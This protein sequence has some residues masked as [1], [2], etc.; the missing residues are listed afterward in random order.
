MFSFRG[1]R[2]AAA[3]PCFNSVKSRSGM[4][5]ANVGKISAVVDPAPR[6][7]DIEAV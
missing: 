5:A 1:E 4:T 7:Q 3:S 6:V 2:L